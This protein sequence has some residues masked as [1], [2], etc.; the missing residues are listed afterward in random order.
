M[1]LDEPDDLKKVTDFLKQHECGLASRTKPLLEKE[2]R[3][4]NNY[5]FDGDTED[6]AKA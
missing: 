5:I 3:K 4:T 1:S 2:G 6:L